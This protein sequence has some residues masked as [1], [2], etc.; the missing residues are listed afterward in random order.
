MLTAVRHHVALAC[1]ALLVFVVVVAGARSPAAAQTSSTI[2]YRPPVEAPVNDPFRAPT[3]PYGPGHRGIEYDTAP[4][5]PVGAVAPGTVVFAGDVAGVRWVTLR[6]PDGVRT[7][8]GPLATIAVVTGQP[9]AGGDVVGTTAGRLLLTA[10]VG[11][12]YVDPALLLSGADEE[13]H[14]VPE[15]ASLPSFPAASFGIDD[16][17][18]PDAVLA[19]LTW[20]RDRAAEKVAAVYGVTPVPFVL[21]TMDALVMWRARQGQ[22]TSSD[23]AV[24]VPANRR[25]AVLIGGLGSTSDDAAI[26]DVDTASLGYDQRDVVRFSYR[27]GR[28]P[29]KHP[30]STELAQ[31]EVNQYATRDTGDDLRV[32]GA[33]LADA[34]SAVAAAA[35]AGTFVDVYAHSQGGLVLRIALDDL[36]ARDPVTLSR[37]GLV[38]TLA[39]PHHGA[40]L[41]G[42]AEALARPP[43]GEQTVDTVAALAGSDLRVQDPAMGQLAPGSDLLRAL[44]AQPLPAGP[45]Y[46]SIAARGDPAVPSP[47]TQLS[48]AQNVVVPVNGLGAHSE[49]PGSAVA[50]H[51]VALALAG[52]PPSC[53]SASDAVLDAIWGNLYHNSEQFLTATRVP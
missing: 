33:R 6:H 14:L 4:G 37:I 44:R 1:A 5:T 10:R 7:T 15:P 42:L 27:G 23:A 43:L 35:P 9:V 29:A 30:L 49:L 36:A 3:S 40:Q 25:L 31:L 52:L 12:D 8:Y 26:D 11:D 41:A 17:L 16:V 50:T 22:C 20:G 24:D 39:T 2:V 46:V 34:L 45:T 47:D 21:G 13:V 32:A 38:V 18:S 53:E 51:E 48:G 19:A 28:V